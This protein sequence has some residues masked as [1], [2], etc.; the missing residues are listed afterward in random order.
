M[1]NIPTPC[2]YS[3]DQA[4]AM[5]GGISA[6]TIHKIINNG[7]LATY[8]VGRRRFVTSDAIADYVAR[9]STTKRATK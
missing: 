6:P 9:H 5:L 3:L 2:G 8:T 7:E 4:R 1:S